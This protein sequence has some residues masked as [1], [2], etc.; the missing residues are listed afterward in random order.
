MLLASLGFILN[1]C[2]GSYYSSNVADWDNIAR[3]KFPAKYQNNE[4]GYVD[5]VP[6]EPFAPG[7]RIILGY[8]NGMN[9]KPTQMIATEPVPGDSTQNFAIIDDPTTKGQD[10]KG[11]IQSKILPERN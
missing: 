4:K 3:A 5:A 7:F 2:A 6:E 9:K 1:G 8:G 10:F 11:E